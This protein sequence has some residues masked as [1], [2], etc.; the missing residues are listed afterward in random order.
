MW[1]ACLTNTKWGCQVFGIP[2]SGVVDSR[3]LVT[4]QGLE[5]WTH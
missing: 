4:R 1:R 2:T 3:Y 5:P